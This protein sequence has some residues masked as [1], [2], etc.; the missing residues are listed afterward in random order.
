MINYFCQTRFVVFSEIHVHFMY[1]YMYS[2]SY[3][4]HKGC[5]CIVM[6]SDVTARVCV[7]L[8]LTSNLT[9]VQ[10]WKTECLTYFGTVWP[11]I[12]LLMWFH[13]YVDAHAAFCIEDIIKIFLSQSITGYCYQNKDLLLR[14]SPGFG[15]RQLL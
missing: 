13:V 10:L 9:D 3:R 15:T 1:F 11:L 6:S 14:I 8:L 7:D 2:Y 4:A 5:T 12:C